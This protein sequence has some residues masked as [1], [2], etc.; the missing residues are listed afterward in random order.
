MIIKKFEP[1]EY[2]S[3]LLN[4]EDRIVLDNLDAMNLK[5]L[6]QGLDGEC[7]FFEKIKDYK[8]CIVLWDISLE[9]PGRAQFDFIVITDEIVYHFDIKNFSG[10]YTYRD[11]NFISSKQYVSSDVISR[12]NRGHQVMQQ[13][14]AQVN[15]NIPFRSRVVFINDSFQLKGFEG[16]ELVLFAEDLHKIRDYL[17]SRTTITK[18]MINLANDIIYHHKP[19]NHF[20]RIHYYAIEDMR[21]GVRCP[22]CRRIGMKHIKGTRKMLCSCGYKEENIEIVFR[23]YDMLLNLGIKKVT[24]TMIVDWTGLEIRCVQKIMKKYYKRLGK[25]R[26]THYIKN[27]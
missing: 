27:K 1:T 19:V 4:I 6:H 22:K 26:A 20:E 15:V 14:L 25:A 23:T 7:L 16:S 21:K 13:F 5:R 8:G 10:K 3:Y 18:N 17:A 2:Q 9:T 12:L 24:A 11:G